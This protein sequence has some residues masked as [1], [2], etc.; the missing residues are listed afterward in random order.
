MADLSNKTEFSNM[1]DSSNNTNLIYYKKLRLNG[2]T[3]IYLDTPVKIKRV[4]GAQYRPVSVRNCHKKVDVNFDEEYF[5]AYSKVTFSLP[6][7]QSNLEKILEFK[8]SVGLAEMFGLYDKDKKSFGVTATIKKAFINYKIED[9]KIDVRMFGE[10]M[11]F[12]FKEK[13]EE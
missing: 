5:E 10:P 7:T 4:G 13:E 11:E 8:K 12:D 2:E 3:P 9:D 6:H 1:T